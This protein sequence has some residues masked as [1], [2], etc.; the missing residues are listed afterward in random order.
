MLPTFRSVEI[1]V[2]AGQ[3]KSCVYKVGEISGGPVWSQDILSGLQQ[4]PLSLLRVEEDLQ[5]L[6]AI[7][8]S[9]LV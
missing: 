7:I 6:L 9:G 8:P 5:E 4:D 1:P 2:R 3:G